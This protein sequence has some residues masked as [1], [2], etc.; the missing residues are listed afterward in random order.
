MC[1]GG[2]AVV[3]YKWTQFALK[4][5]YVQLAMFFVWLLSFT[6]FTKL[7]QACLPLV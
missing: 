2:Q 7:F 3:D 1:L 4:L 5:L 6:V